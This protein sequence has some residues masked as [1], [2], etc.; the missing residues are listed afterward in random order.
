MSVE[1]HD[2]LIALL[3]SVE[4]FKQK[5]TELRAEKQRHQEQIAASEAEVRRCDEELGDIRENQLRLRREMDGLKEDLFRRDEDEETIV[6]DTAHIVTDGEKPSVES[7]GRRLWK[8]RQ[9]ALRTVEGM[10]RR[11]SSEMP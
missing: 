6:E 3:S 2:K 10:F 11:R 5:E 8:E 7:E 9:K 4:E 1:I